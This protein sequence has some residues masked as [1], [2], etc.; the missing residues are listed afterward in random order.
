MKVGIYYGSTTGVTE[1]IANDIAAALNNPETVVKS[2]AQ[3]D[4]EE[5]DEQELLILGSSTWG[6]GELQDDW[7]SGIE[8][9]KNA[10]LAGKR[11]AL[12][13]VGDQNGWS[14][15]FVDAMG[16]IYAAIADSGATFIGSWPADGYDFVESKS[17]IDGKFV[18]LALDETNQAADTATR[19]STWVASLN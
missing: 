10:N 4:K 18:G 13:G 14:D 1:S 16:L 2:I 3:A 7:E 6:C 5:I 8:L 9:I 19:I 12:F 15:T 17:I 11:V